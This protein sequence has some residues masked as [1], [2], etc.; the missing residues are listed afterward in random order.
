MC[1]FKPIPSARRNS[2][3]SKEDADSMSA[4]LPLY[5]GAI[6]S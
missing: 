3:N 2:M 1:N 6:S 5:K 4:F